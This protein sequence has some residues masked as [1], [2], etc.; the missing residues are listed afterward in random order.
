MYLHFHVPEVANKEVT[1]SCSNQAAEKRLDLVCFMD[2]WSC[3]SSNFHGAI[4]AQKYSMKE[5]LK[6]K[7]DGIYISSDESVTQAM[8]TI[9]FLS[10]MCYLANFCMLSSLY[11]IVSTAIQRL[12]GG[13]LE[14]KIRESLL[15]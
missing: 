9:Q 12:L 15:P 1:G 11:Q 2:L 4:L 14:G 6:S 10:L 7:T 5:P 3:I 13:R 8:K